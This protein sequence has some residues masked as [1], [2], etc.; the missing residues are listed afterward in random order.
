MKKLCTHLRAAVKHALAQ[1]SITPALDFDLDPGI[2]RLDAVSKPFTDDQKA[3]ASSSSLYQTFTQKHAARKIDPSYKSELKHWRD[4]YETGKMMYRQIV[5]P[6]PVVLRNLH[7]CRHRQLNNRAL[8]PKVN[9]TNCTTPILLQ[10]AEGNHAH[11]SAKCTWT[12]F[13]WKVPAGCWWQ[14]NSSTEKVCFLPPSI[15]PRGTRYYWMN[16]CPTCSSWVITLNRLAKCICDTGH[17]CRCGTGEMKAWLLNCC[18]NRWSISALISNSAEGKNWFVRWQRQHSI[19]AG[20]TL[21]QK[22]MKQLVEQLFNCEQPM[23]LPMAIHLYRNEERRSRTSLWPLIIFTNRFQKRSTALR[24]AVA[25]VLWLL[26]NTER[27]ATGSFC[28]DVSA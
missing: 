24:T 10:H 16:C 17:S 5:Y 8:L 19:K 12:Y 26:T 20:R 4:L 25:V 15:S 18:W 22:E 9:S 14:T 11:S 3:A 7:R 2:Q 1:F 13:I 21:S 28:N 6:L 23:L 27:W